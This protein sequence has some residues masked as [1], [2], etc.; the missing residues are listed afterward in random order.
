MT[1]GFERFINAIFGP[2]ARQIEQL[3]PSLARSIFILL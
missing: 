2:L 3:P 1:A